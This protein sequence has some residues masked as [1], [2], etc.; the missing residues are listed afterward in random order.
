MKL[1]NILYCRVFCKIAQ[2]MSNLSFQNNLNL[3]N[4]VITGYL[5]TLSRDFYSLS[6]HLSPQLLL[7]VG[8]NS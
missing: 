1:K 8:N 6:P 4:L 2:R 7:Y 5:E 3:T